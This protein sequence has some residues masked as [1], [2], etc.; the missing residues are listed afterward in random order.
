MIFSAANTMPRFSIRSDE[1]MLGV[2]DLA[3]VY[4]QEVYILDQ[5]RAE[6]L[7][8]GVTLA[9]YQEAQRLFSSPVF[10]SHHVVWRILSKLAEEAQ[11]LPP[12]PEAI[13]AICGY[14]STSRNER[15]GPWVVQSD[16]RWQLS[17]ILPDVIVS[18]GTVRTRPE[19]T[20]II[21]EQFGKVVAFHRR[22]I[23][24]AFE[25]SIATTLYD[26]LCAQRQ[27]APLTPGGL[28]W[29][30]P[31]QLRI[32]A[33]NLQHVA[34]CCAELG[35]SILGAAAQHPIVDDIQGAWART[36]TGRILSAEHF[37]LM[38]DTYLKKRYRI[39]PRTT[40]DDADYAFRH[41]DGYNRDPA[42]MLPPIRWLLPA[43]DATIDEHV[44][45]TIAGRRYRDDLLRF[46]TDTPV[47]TRVS[48]HDPHFAYIY[49][50]GKILCV[51]LQTA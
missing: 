41:L 46:W 33:A 32:N 3:G 8:R 4:G 22:K 42:L 27:P 24:E 29:S 48:R 39:G 51:A 49:L 1:D 45:V 23:G 31:R 30:P 15:V 20:C 19:I 11:V 36:L 16:A 28:V 7:F 2:R 14:L 47:T 12:T 43:Y 5:S 35:I 18:S 40:A 10:R 25:E 34:N 17:Y 6:Q 26:A 37:D 44:A 21:D 38:L 13:W 50:D 9:V